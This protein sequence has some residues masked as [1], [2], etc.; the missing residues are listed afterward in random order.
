MALRHQSGLFELRDAIDGHQIFATKPDAS[1]VEKAFGFNGNRTL[2]LLLADAR[3]PARGIDDDKTAIVT[4]VVLLDVRPYD[5][6]IVAEAKQAVARCLTPAEATANFLP[7]APPLWCIGKWPYDS[8]EMQQWAKD[9][10]AG[11]SPKMPRH[12]QAER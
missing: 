4:Q 11:R 1:K 7:E 2:V 5:Q 9:K 8:P 3:T 12:L 6:P 10:R